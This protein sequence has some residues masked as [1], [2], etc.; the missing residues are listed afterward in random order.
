MIKKKSDARD[1]QVRILLTNDDGI[2]AVGLTALGS[3][4]KGLGEVW[5]VAPERPQS[6][7]GRAM[8]LHKPLRLTQLGKRKFA[9]NGTPADC[10]TLAVGKLME[11]HKPD[12]IV[13]GINKGLNIGD[14]VTNSGTVSGAIEGMLHGIPSIAVSQDDE[15][16]CRFQVAGTYVLRL[17]KLVLQFGLP[18]DLLLNMNVP[19]CPLTKIAGV[20]MTSL[21]QRRYLNPIIEKVDPRGRQYYWIAGERVSWQRKKTSDHEAVSNRMVSI[22]PLH[23]DMTEYQALKTLRTWESTLNLNSKSVGRKGKPRDKASSKSK[24][25]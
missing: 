16:P 18:K 14:D 25:K 4:L 17:A 23:L 5:V 21:S 20:T 2:G 3:A 24:A 11:K 10:V 19:N 13:S 9:V 8:T 12:L 15:E 1:T 22:T 6:A 7:V